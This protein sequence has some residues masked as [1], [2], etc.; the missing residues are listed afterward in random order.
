[1]SGHPWMQSND[2]S[3]GL[4]CLPLFRVSVPPP[5]NTNTLRCLPMMLPLL[6]ITTAVFQIVS[7]CA[8]SRSRIGQMTT[9]PHL[10]AGGGVSAGLRMQASKLSLL[11][12]RKMTRRY[13]ACSQLPGD[14]WQECATRD[15]PHVQAVNASPTCGLHADTGRR[16]RRSRPTRQ[17]HTTAS[18][19]C[20]RQTAWACKCTVKERQRGLPLRC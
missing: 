6:P 18:H 2:N 14:E 15:S 20:R 10:G 9:M 1:M 8:S 5:C 11:R 19:G 7:P 13:T 4:P 12:W 3:S 17:T 16:S